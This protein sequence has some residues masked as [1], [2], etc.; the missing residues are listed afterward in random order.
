MDWMPAEAVDARAAKAA[1]P[2]LIRGY[3]R[4]GARF[5]EGCVVDEG[6]GTTDVFVVLPVDGIGRRYIS[7]Y[8]GGPANT[9]RAA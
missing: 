8:G 5:G 9:R 3:L 2:A 7:Y 4:L 6:F 1:L